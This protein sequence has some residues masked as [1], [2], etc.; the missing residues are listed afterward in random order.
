MPTRILI[1]DDSPPMRVA[2]R[3]LLSRQGWEV[4][5]AE[6][7][8]EAIAKAQEIKPEIVILDLAM[9]QV[10]GLTASRRITELLPDIPVLMYTMHFT[11]QLDIEARKFGVRRMVAKPESNVLVAA[12]RELLN[13]ET[14]SNMAAPEAPPLTSIPRSV[15]ESR[16]E[17]APSLGRGNGTDGILT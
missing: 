4:L 14:R 3:S 15:D 16:L 5:E 11:G 1:A 6:N 7:G 8:M 12:I 17:T 13:K 2:L 10:D 9:P